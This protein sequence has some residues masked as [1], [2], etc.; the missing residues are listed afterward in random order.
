MKVINRE[1]SSKNSITER[2][3]SSFCQAS[4]NSDGNLTLRNYNNHDKESDE[5]IILT[6]TETQAIFKLISEMKNILPNSLPF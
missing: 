6:I 3:G 5:I 1:M 2:D 4:F